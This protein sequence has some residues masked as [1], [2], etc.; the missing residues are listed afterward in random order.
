MESFKSE[1]GEFKADKKHGC[2]WAVV[3]GRLWF[4]PMFE[5]GTPDRE[6]IGDVEIS[7]LDIIADAKKIVGEF[8]ESNIVID[9]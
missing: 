7:A 9:I 4:C 2:F 5:D 3:D 6:N 8:D 1:F